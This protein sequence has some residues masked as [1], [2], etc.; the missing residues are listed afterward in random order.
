M[1]NPATGPRNKSLADLPKSLWPRSPLTFR[2]ARKE[3]LVQEITYF[4][5]DLCGLRF[6]ETHAQT[7]RT[8][9]Y[10]Q[11]VQVRNK[12]VHLLRGKIISETFHLVPAQH[13]H[14]PHPVIIRRHAAHAQ[15]RFFKHAL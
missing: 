8:L 7:T 11:R 14:I 5:C 9:R 15:I 2:E 12:I 6:Y 10:S 3:I 1:V 4:L 13:D